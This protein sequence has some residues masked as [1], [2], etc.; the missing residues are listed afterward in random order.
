MLL[1]LT[2]AARLRMFLA[3]PLALQLVILEH[4]Y[5]QYKQS[6][7]FTTDMTILFLSSNSL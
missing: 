6:A 7:M 3:V 4:L 1:L 5:V 2:V